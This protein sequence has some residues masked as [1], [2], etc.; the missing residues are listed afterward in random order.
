[1]APAVV[2]LS[3]WSA[4][5]VLAGPLRMPGVPEPLLGLAETATPW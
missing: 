4:V 3:V 2:I 1:M 5:A